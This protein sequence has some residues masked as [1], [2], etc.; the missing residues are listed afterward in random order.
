MATSKPKELASYSVV[1]ILGR[2]TK[3]ELAEFETFLCSPY[4]NQNTY[5]TSLFR[6]LKKYYPAFESPAFTSQNI[7]KAVNKGK[8]YD[9]S[10]SRKDMLSLFGLAEKYL[11]VS[12]MLST[13]FDSR[14]YL[15]SSYHKKSMPDLGRK[16]IGKIKQELSSKG[17]N[18][19]DSYQYSSRLRSLEYDMSLLNGNISDALI[20]E[21]RSLNELIKFFILKS[22]NLINQIRFGEKAYN[23]KDKMKLTD[24]FFSRIDLEK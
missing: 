24:A 14:F 4:F 10:Q 8:R 19:I 18:E 6:E 22:V 7:F 1:R 12:G 11:S 16:A 13:E 9:H 3:S 15:V 21:K 5:L 23:I 20:S 2:L 17:H